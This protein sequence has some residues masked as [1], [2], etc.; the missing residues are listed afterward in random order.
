M[1]V[2]TSL[3][4]LCII[5]PRISIESADVR[6]CIEIMEAAQLSGW[7]YAGYWG[8]PIIDAPLKYMGKEADLQ[9][10]LRELSKAR[11]ICCA[12]SDEIRAETVAKWSPFV[13]WAN[14]VHPHASVSPS[15]TIGAGTF[16]GAHATI[17][18]RVTLAPHSVVSAHQMIKF[19]A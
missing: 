5:A 11:F 9:A 19:N 17:L 13:N 12:A 1:P 16:I 15:A 7:T 2:E 18:P 4:M 6:L 8:V 3:G 14:V 10:T